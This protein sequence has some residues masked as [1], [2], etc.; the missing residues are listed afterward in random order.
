[1]TLVANVFGSLDPC[2]AFNKS[3]KINSSNYKEV[4]VRQ[5]TGDIYE[6]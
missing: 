5:I 6:T 1:M 3:L 2:V 4:R